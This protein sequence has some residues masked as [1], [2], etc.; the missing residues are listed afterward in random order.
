MPEF[1]PFPNLQTLPSGNRFW[2]IYGTIAQIQPLTRAVWMEMK[3]AATGLPIN[4][5]GRRWMASNTSQIGV[6][7][8]ILEDP[9]TAGEGFTNT[10]R[11]AIEFSLVR[12][13][14]MNY[15]FVVN[16]QVALL[17]HAAPAETN[18]GQ[19]RMLANFDTGMQY[20]GFQD[21][22][23]SLIIPR[24]L[25]MKVQSGQKRVLLVSVPDY[26]DVSAEYQAAASELQGH[27]ELRG[28]NFRRSQSSNTIRSST[29]IRG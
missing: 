9:R 25:P 17:G 13:D 15:S 11:Q 26:V 22:Y 23:N 14:H 3:S 2:W 20:F 5:G 7:L 4:E 28:P 10:Y 12:A 21:L 29:A 24:T 18:I 27:E 6:V 8:H 19:P 16:D 1:L